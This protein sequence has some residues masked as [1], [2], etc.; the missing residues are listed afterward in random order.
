MS[1]VGKPQI[2]RGDNF[3][4]RFEVVDE[5][6]SPISLIGATI[7]WFLAHKSMAPILLTKTIGSDLVVTD[8][9]AGKFEIR[10]EQTETAA[11]EGEYYHQATVIFPEDFK[12]TVSRGYLTVLPNIVGA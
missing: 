2:P 12:S 1:Q 3:L 11:L 5:V 10:L 7:T 8:A 4:L 9:S 6:G